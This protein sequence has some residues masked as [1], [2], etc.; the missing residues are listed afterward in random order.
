MKIRSRT[1]LGVVTPVNN[2][3]APSG[4]L[5]SGTL[6]RDFKPATVSRLMAVS[7]LLMPVFSGEKSNCSQSYFAWA[8]NDSSNMVVNMDPNLTTFCPW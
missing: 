7:K 4:V 6:K 8:W 5:A 2:T 1:P 3:G